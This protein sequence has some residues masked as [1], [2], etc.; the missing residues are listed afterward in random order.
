MALSGNHSPWTPSNSKRSSI[1]SGKIPHFMTIS[2]KRVSFSFPSKKKKDDLF[3]HSQGF[4][5]CLSKTSKGHY[6]NVGK[7]RVKSSWKES[8]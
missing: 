7:R 3:L 4:G 5:Q 2:K 6:V 8:G 1:K